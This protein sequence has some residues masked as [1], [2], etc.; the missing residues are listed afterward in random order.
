MVQ[1]SEDREWRSWRRLHWYSIDRVFPT[2]SEL[3]NS[4]IWRHCASSFSSW[5]GIQKCI[6]NSLDQNP[7]C[8]IMACNMGENF[9]LWVSSKGKLPVGRTYHK[10][11]IFVIS[12]C[13]Y[14]YKYRCRIS[15]N[16]HYKPYYL[17]TIF[18]ACHFTRWLP[19]MI[20]CVNPANTK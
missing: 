4:T 1:H 6:V 10:P 14:S 5:W 8:S 16:H 12:I 17:L 11:I 13:H 2:H 20:L 3:P 7:M 9:S 19:S 18:N 15:H